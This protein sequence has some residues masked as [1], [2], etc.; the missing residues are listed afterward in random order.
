[1]ATETDFN[2]PSELLVIDLINEANGTKFDTN[3]F[4]IVDV[5]NKGN[6]TPIEGTPHVRETCATL[7]PFLGGRLRATTM[8]HYHRLNASDMFNDVVVPV[9][10]AGQTSTYDLLEDINKTL[11][12]QLTTNDIILEPVSTRVLPSIGTVK[13]KPGNPAWTGT[14]W[15]SIN[16]VPYQLE[17]WVTQRNLPVLDYPTHQTERIQGPLYAYPHDFSDH[18]DQLLTYSN[19][20]PTDALLDVFKDV[21]PFDTWVLRA[22]PKPFNLMGSL[23]LYNGNIR[24]PW[25]FRPGFKY[26]L[27]IE[28]SSE[29]CTNIAGYLVLHYNVKGE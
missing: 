7:R 8:I 6:L 13:I 10:L 15:F 12:L 25:S 22:Q 3:D 19:G 27:V 28:L 29:F 9:A 20:S 21:L 26:I 18:G 14:V 11:G 5:A 17:E 23:V 24:E 1:M 4:A 16:R 2:K